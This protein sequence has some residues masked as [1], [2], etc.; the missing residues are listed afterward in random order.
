MYDGIRKLGTLEQRVMGS[1]VLYD[2]NHDRKIQRDEIESMMRAA[3][4]ISNV[5]LPE[6]KFDQCMETLMSVVDV[7][8]VCSYHLLPSNPVF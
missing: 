5:S 8:K 7:D 6:E 2:P 1:F 4:D 3:R